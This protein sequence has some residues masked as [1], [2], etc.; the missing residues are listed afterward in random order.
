MR[1]IVT[2]GII[3]LVVGVLIILFISLVLPNLID[4][5]ERRNW[6]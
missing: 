2:G 1:S 3:G 5:W 6:N 4:R